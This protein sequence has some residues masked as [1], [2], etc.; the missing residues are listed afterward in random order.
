M[1]DLIPGRDRWT[2]R[3]ISQKSGSSARDFCDQYPIEKAQRI[4]WAKCWPSHP[5]YL[6]LHG[7]GNNKTWRGI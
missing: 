4:R 2:V 7:F 1:I 6:V 5:C 3:N